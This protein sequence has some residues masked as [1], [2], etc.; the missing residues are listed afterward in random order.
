[1]QKV[2]NSSVRFI[3]NLSKHKH[4]SPYIKQ[5][6]FLSME[7]RIKFKSNV[8]VFRMLKLNNNCPQYLQSIF[9]I[10]NFVCN[11]RSSSDLFILEYNDYTGYKFGNNSIAR[12]M[13]K[14]WNDLPANLRHLENMEKFKKDLKTYYFALWLSERG[15]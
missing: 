2:I 15:L 4:I 14:N 6:H 8:F 12:K 5:C 9:V 3:Y 11:T 10:K 7:H 1:M 13:V